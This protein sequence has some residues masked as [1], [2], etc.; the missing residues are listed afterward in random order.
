MNNRLRRFRFLLL[1]ALGGIVIALA[2]GSARATKA[3]GA[4][5]R[6]A[7]VPHVLLGPLAQAIAAGKRGG[8]QSTCVVGGPLACYAPSQLQQAYDFPT[9]P[10]A[11][12]GRG[13]TILIVS[14]YGAD[15]IR[16]DLASFDAALGIPAPP[17]F[18][19]YNQKTQ[20]PGADGSGDRFSWE[21]ETSLDVEYAH[22][23][24]PG[25]NIVLAVASSDDSGDIAEVETEALPMYPGAIVSQSF[26]GDESGDFSDPSAPGILEPLYGADIAAGGTIVA[27]SGDYGATNGDDTL[28]ASYPASDPLVLAVGGT[29]GHPYPLGLVHRDGSYG[30]EQAWNEADFGIAGGGAPSTMFPAPTWQ[31]G[32]TGQTMRAEPDVSFTAA[33]NGGVVVV[34]SCLPGSGDALACNPGAP[35]AGVVGG[36][37]VGS[38]QWAAIVAIANEARGRQG[39]PPVGQVAPLLYALAANRPTYNQD[40]HDITVGDNVLAGSNLGFTARPGYDL[41]TGLGTPDVAQLVDDLT[42]GPKGPVPPSKPPHPGPPHGGHGHVDPGK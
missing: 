36:T 10:H 15:D 11:P 27:S 31:Q 28:M 5:M 13:Q 6:P 22:A 41:A 33:L 38:P 25:A 2:G 26:G 14:A 12:I 23:M 21:I 30:G 4:I 9:D 8:S 7:V 20:V 3:H 40:F 35:V 16:Y 39:K 24:A 37:S 29:E 18:T 17:S 32:I 34:L 19:I 1:L 42:R